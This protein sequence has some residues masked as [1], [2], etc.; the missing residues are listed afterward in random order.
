M[1]HVL[2]IGGGFGGVVAAESLAERLGPE[3]QITLVSRHREFTFFPALVRLAFGRVA[4][5]DVFYDLEQAMLSRRIEFLQAEIVAL[6]PNARHVRMLQGMREIEMPYDYLIFALGRRLAVEHIP[7]F[8]AHAHHPLT[9]GAA[10]RFRE[11][12]KE[13]HQ[14]R[15]V[16]GYCPD[17]RLAVPVYET[18]FALDR[19]MR[20]RGCRDQVS[21]SII[22]PESVGGSLCGAVAPQLQT[23]LENHGIEFIP[24]F[25]ADFITA[26]HVWGKDSQSI[27][28]DLL[29]LI[30]PFQGLYE[31]EFSSITDRQNYICVDDQ[32]RSTRIERLYAVGDAVNFPG[33]KMAHMAVL[34]GEV[35]AANV[36]AEIDGRKPEARYNH[37]MML[38]INEGGEDS[39][40]MNYKFWEDRNPA[41]RQGRFWGWAKQVH[42]KYWTQLHSLKPVV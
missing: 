17:S 27:A 30:P 12:I 13:F 11:A 22:S 16:V 25:A 34:Q 10:L 21:I 2:I 3:D 35:A 1:A 15:A 4:V 41:I 19:A 38:V 6:D 42:E 37:Q 31:T 36:A 33:P 5:D 7:G 28:Y 39:I 32:M 29:M 9:V 24:D 20:E 40:Y 26:K 14:G 18:A 23:A 8:V